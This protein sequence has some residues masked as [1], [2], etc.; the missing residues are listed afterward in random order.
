MNCF[1]AYRN[2]D[3]PALADL[4]N[5]ATPERGAVRPLS[6][7]EF[8]AL[9]IGR[10]HF[11]AAGLIVAERGGHVVGFAH[12]GFGPE[13][14]VGRSHRLDTSMGTV[15]MVILEP[16]LDDPG[17]ERDLVFEAERYL[18]RRGACVFYAGGQAPL[19]PT[20]WGIYGGSEFSG[21]LDSHIS[22]RRVVETAGYEPAATTV[23]FEIDLIRG[24]PKDARA[25]LFRRQFRLEVI[26]DVLPN[27]WWQALAIGLFRPTAFR[28]I[29]K[30][31]N[32]VVAHAITWDIPSGY[33]MGDGRTRTGLIDVGVA[34]DQRRRGYGRHL[35]SEI[36]RHVRTRSTDA[37]VV[38]TSSQ[39]VPALALYRSLG[40][41]AI[42]TATLYRLPA[43]LGQRSLDL[44]TLTGDEDL[45]DTL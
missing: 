1:R 28:L 29:E 45:A 2:G 8:D 35:V 44:E 26:E 31:T 43:E 40:F 17:L 27:G 20:Y 9:A 24:E 16:G 30:P 41:E 37:V 42:D 23:I 12:A 33:G 15:A 36:L 13:Q 4:W 6:V 32:Q 39:N 22:F 19:N 21:I 11:E 38:Q 3:S 5:R 7:H 25:P 14:P 18:R 10:L 34:S